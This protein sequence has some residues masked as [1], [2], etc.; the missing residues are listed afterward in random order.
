MAIIIMIIYSNLWFYLTWEIWH[1]LLL[2]SPYWLTMRFALSLA[3]YGHINI[4][5]Y[6]CS[7]LMLEI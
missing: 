1:Y 4:A 3:H 5:I 2:T 6:I 7:Y